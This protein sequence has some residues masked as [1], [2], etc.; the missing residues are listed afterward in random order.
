MAILEYLEIMIK[1]DIEEDNSEILEYVLKVAY[2]FYPMVYEDSKGIMHVGGTKADEEF[3][4]YYNKGEVNFLSYNEYLNDVEI[5]ANIKALNLGVDKFYLLIL[6]ITHA[7]KGQWENPYM[8]HVYPHAQVESFCE[9]IIREL[10]SISDSHAEFSEEASITL[11]IGKKKIIVDNALAIAYIG[12]M[13]DKM[14]DMVKMTRDY[15]SKGYDKK[16]EKE[17]FYKKLNALASPNVYTYY[18][19]VNKKEITVNYNEALFSK[20]FDID[21]L[22]ESTS[23]SQTYLIGHFA[24]MFDYFLKE[25]ETPNRQSFTNKDGERIV[26][27]KYKLISKL[28]G[29]TKLTQNKK[30][31]E[32]FLYDEGS[33]VKGYIAALKKA[34]IK[35]DNKFY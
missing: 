4:Y 13:A 34:K 26:I 23:T 9:T 24:T 16:E 27:S 5:Q 29:L 32:D 25:Y 18:D 14:F 1:L 19:G 35:T 28:I 8:A 17:E 15:H 20:A 3:E 2:K 22:Y 10:K 30:T 11:K 7:S 21:N 33:K 6:F 31:D 12:T